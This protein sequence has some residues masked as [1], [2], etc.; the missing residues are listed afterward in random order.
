MLKARRVRN[1]PN[2]GA[3]TYLEVYFTFEEV[4]WGKDTLFECVSHIWRHISPFRSLGVEDTLFDAF[5]H[6]WRYVSPLRRTLGKNTLFRH[7]LHIWRRALY[8]RRC[9]V[10][11]LTWS[12]P[13]MKNKCMF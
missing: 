6:I 10:A 5:L 13:Q 11:F 9:H 4:F 1:N 3:S 12:N 2:G 7:F 8:M